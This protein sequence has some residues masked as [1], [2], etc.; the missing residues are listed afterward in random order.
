ME[1]NCAFSTIDMLYLLLSSSILI[2]KDGCC[3]M[4]H[5]NVEISKKKN[6]SSTWDSQ[7]VSNTSTNQAQQCLTSEI[8]RDLV[9]SLW[10][11]RW[12]SIHLHFVIKHGQQ[13]CHFH[14]FLMSILYNLRSCVQF[15]AISLKI[16][17]LIVAKHENT[18]R[19]RALHRNRSFS[20]KHN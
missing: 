14:I 9:Y 5:R 1:Q 13:K 8:E 3:S 18:L 4:E 7:F 11:G 20:W 6:A 12:Q 17:L 19:N 16:R 10:Y 2:Q 15:R